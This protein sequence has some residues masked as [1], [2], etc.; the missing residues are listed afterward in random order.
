MY[1]FFEHR[2][3]YE[4]LYGLV[5]SEMCIRDRVRMYTVGDE[6]LGAIEHIAVALAARGG[7]NAFHV[8][9]R[10]FYI[11]DTADE[12]RDVDHVGHR[13]IQNKK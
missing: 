5:G 8:R 13:N 7:A 3:A 10:L 2:P 9:A 12:Q 1:F 11:Y 6:H 4:I